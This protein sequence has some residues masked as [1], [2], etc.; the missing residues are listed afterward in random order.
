M[1]LKPPPALV[2]ALANG[3]VG[4]L[5]V[6][7]YGVSNL[8]QAWRLSPTRTSIYCLWHQSLVSVLAPHQRRRHIRIAALASLSGDGE[9]IADY[10][11][12]VGIRPVRGSSARGSARAA[13]E[14]FEALAEGWNLAIAIDGPRGPA[15]RVKPGPLEVSRRHGVPIVPIAARASRELCFSRSWDRFRLPLPRA[16]LAVIYGEPI[17]YPPEDPTDAELATRATELERRLEALEARAT[18]LV[19]RHAGR[20]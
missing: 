14:L 18:E 8:V 11:R 16:H 20:R 12:R 15:K 2:H 7:R 5:R 13:K 9:I 6:H 17:L 3:L 10:L 19:T 4:T 1:R